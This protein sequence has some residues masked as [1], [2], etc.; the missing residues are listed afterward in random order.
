MGRN[1]FLNI[2]GAHRPPSTH[3]ADPGWLFGR[4]GGL[5]IFF[6]LIGRKENTVWF[7]PHQALVQG[8]VYAPGLSV[9]CTHVAFTL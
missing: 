8:R 9:L 5:E 3:P 7:G 4:P 2:E 6:F 1:V